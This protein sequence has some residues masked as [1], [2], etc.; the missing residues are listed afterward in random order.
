MLAGDDD[1]C[2]LVN[3]EP[4]AVQELHSWTARMPPGTYT[5]TSPP[6]LICGAISRMNSRNAREENSAGIGPVRNRTNTPPMPVFA[7]LVKASSMRSC[8]PH[9][10]GNPGCAFAFATI[11]S[12]AVLWAAR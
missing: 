10:T 8:E 2:Q 3:H 7:R 11:A 4:E 9:S 12:K 5:G 6:S 1:V